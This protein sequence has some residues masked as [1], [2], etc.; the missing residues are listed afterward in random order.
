MIMK[1]GEKIKLIHQ[2]IS[3]V[4]H[5]ACTEKDTVVIERL[6]QVGVIIKD[7]IRLI[8]KEGSNGSIL[9]R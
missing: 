7:L 2:L 3:E 8:K 5:M 4:Y 9:R 6:E 1:V